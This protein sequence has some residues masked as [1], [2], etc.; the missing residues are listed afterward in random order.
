MSTAKRIILACT[1]MAAVATSARAANLPLPYPTKAEPWSAAGTEARLWLGSPD[2]VLGARDA[3]RAKRV[4]D[5]GGGTAPEQDVA[6]AI[7][8]RGVKVVISTLRNEENSPCGMIG[9]IVETSGAPSEA[10]AVQRVE[11]PPG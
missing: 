2:Q 5:I 8:A 4:T 11:D 1:A 9:G 3:R 10:G 7:T 6:R